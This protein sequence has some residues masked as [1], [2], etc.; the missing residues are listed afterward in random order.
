[1]LPLRSAFRVSAETLRQSPLRTVLSTLGIVIGVAS[2]V[3]ILSLGDGMERFVHTEIG[4][5]TDLQM[6]RLSPLATRTVDGTPIPRADT[7]RF[8]PDDAGSLAASLDDS[9]LVGVTANGVA[10]TTARGEQ[11][12]V[13]VIA[14]SP[15]LASVVNLAVGAGRPLSA[16][17]ANEPR[18]LLSSKA[19]RE[20]APAGAR[21]LGPGDSLQ[22]GGVRFAIIGILS[23]EQSGSSITAVAPIRSAALSIVRGDRDWAPSLVL[24]AP[25][26]EAVTAMRAGS[27]RWLAAHYGT[28]W[29]D[30]VE[31]DGNT[32]L[33]AKAERGILLFKMFMGAITGISLVVGGIGVMNV[34]LAAIAERTRE[35]GVRRAVGAARR[36]I[37]AQFLAESVTITGL[38]SA[39]GIVLG[40]ASSYGITAVLRSRTQLPVYAGTSPNT[41]IVAV[42]MAVAVGLSFGLYP[43]LRAARLSPIDAIH[44]E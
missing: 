10:L 25:S 1:M 15:A 13:R 18:L 26:I 5:S 17:D 39:V 33:V 21:A 41:L 14:I 30:R 43:A 20:L 28:Q 12:A 22:L 34:L 8:T 9:V 2:L 7:V 31:L 37:L 29:H 19:A 6:I 32:K 23:G 38:G 16:A 42:G 11:R 27:E 36:H 24:R 44:N 4:A 40:L 3:A 35:I